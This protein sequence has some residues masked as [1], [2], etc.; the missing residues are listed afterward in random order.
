MGG[1]TSFLVYTTE[2]I[3][4]L[5]AHELASGDVVRLPPNY[6]PEPFPIHA[7]CAAGRRMPS[8]VRLFVDFL[9]D[10]CVQEP[11]LRIR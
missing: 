1:L 10:L 3:L 4:E 8:R 5:N 2:Q 9:A 6:A 11:E 7:V